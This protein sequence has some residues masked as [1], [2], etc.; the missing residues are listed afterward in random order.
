MRP[1]LMIFAAGLGTRMRPL[2]DHLPKPLIEVGGQTL[3]DR[4]LALG[5]Q[6]GVARIVVNSHYLGCRI[7]AHLA[8]QEVAISDEAALLLDT[9]GGLRRALPLL[10]Q[11]P[12]LTLNPDVVW[13]GPNPL[14]ALIAA[15]RP[16]MEALLML[17]PRDRATARVGPGDFALDDAGRISRRGDVVYGGAQIIR[18]DLL[19]GI[20]EAVFSLNRA[21]DLMIA[22][23][24]AHGILHAGGW[25]DVG[26]PEAI[27]QAE[28]LL[29]KDAP[30]G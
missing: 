17:V 4:A 12:V 23:G 13:T 7:A 1:P 10:G 28:A 15:W 11:G 25:C 24:T 29:A 22:R 27:A 14:A 26:R 9:G 18:P 8:G 21:W 20:G 2:T 16:D 6:A 19:A 30:H 5:R 3:L